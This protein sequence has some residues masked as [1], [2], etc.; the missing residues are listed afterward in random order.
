MDIQT[1]L[2][3]F[4][5]VYFLFALVMGLDHRIVAG[6]TLILLFGAMISWTM[7][8]QELAYDLADQVFY[9]MILTVALAVAMPIRVRLVGPGVIGPVRRLFG[10]RGHEKAD[11]LASSSAKDRLKE[12]SPSYCSSGKTSGSHGRSRKASGPHGRSRKASGSHGRSRK[13][14]GSHG[15]SRKVSGPHGSSGKTSGPH[16][17]SGKTS[18]SHGRSRKDSTAKERIRKVH[19]PKDRPAHQPDDR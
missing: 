16:G 3:A 9:M 13:V 15:R 10:D 17:S 18:G 2:M 5:V 1:M 6:A 8:N 12:G 4:L 19:V 14:S 7:D 11:D